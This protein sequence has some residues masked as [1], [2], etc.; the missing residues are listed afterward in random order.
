MS[1]LHTTESEREPQGRES[2]TAR[3]ELAPTHLGT[4]EAA[5][6]RVENQSVPR[7]SQPVPQ[8]GLSPVLTKY[9]KY[10]QSYLRT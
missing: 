1:S 9:K 6:S 10:L 4:D 7:P 2:D 8:S 5:S 3:N